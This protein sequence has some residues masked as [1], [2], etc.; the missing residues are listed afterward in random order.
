MRVK[1][2][3][4]FTILSWGWEIDNFPVY[5]TCYIRFALLYYNIV[6]GEKYEQVLESL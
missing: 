3:W 5:L 6:M 2:G 4:I 1:G